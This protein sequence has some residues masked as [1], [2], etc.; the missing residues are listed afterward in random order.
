MSRIFLKTIAPDV[1]LTT[2]TLINASRIQFPTLDNGRLQINTVIPPAIAAPVNTVQPIALPFDVYVGSIATVDTGTWTGSTP[3]TYT[4]QWYQ[5]D[6][7]G[8][9]IIPGA[10]NSFYTVTSDDLSYNLFANVTATN[11]G[12]SANIDSTQT[13]IVIAPELPVNTVLPVISGSVVVGQTLTLTSIGTWT[14]TPAPTYTYQW[15]SDGSYIA[16]Q[17]GSTYLVVSGDETAEF[18]CIVFATNVAGSVIATSN[19]LS[20]AELPVNTVAP[21]ISG[22]VRIGEVLTSTQGTWTGTPTPTYAYQWMRDGVAI[23]G[24]TASTHTV[25]AADIA[26]LITCEV[27]ATNIAGSVSEESNTLASPWQPILAAK[28]NVLIFDGLDP[29]CYGGVSVSSPVTDM[30]AVNGATIGTQATS[31]KCGTRLSNA[32]SLD[33]ADDHYLCD[34]YGSIFEGAHT[35]LVGFDDPGAAGATRHMLAASKATSSTAT[36]AY[37]FTYVGGANSTNTQTIYTHDG[38]S[39]VRVNLFGLSAPYDL[40]T[41]NAGLGGAIE[42]DKLDATLTAIASGTRPAVAQTYE[43]LTLGALSYGAGATKTAYWVGKIRHLALDDEA[44]DDTD[45]LLYRTCAI[46]AGVM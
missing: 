45:T 29:Y 32:L 28:P 24:A 37:R 40:V 8:D 14:G 33:G 38:K 21:V 4:Y 19:T 10:I 22:T 44:W 16:G 20:G 25:V 15:T 2:N 43:R 30:K 12:G 17:T 3:I 42:N 11:I 27:T 7:G 18:R 9:F 35:V 34:S 1:R 23:G 6:G 41:R 39:L 26:E 13:G 36:L 46:A 31:G 5:T